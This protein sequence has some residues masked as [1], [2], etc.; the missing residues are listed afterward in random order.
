MREKFLKSTMKSI[1]NKYPDYDK[2]RLEIIEYGLESLYIMITK[3]IVISLIALLLNV[4]KE[5]LIIMILYN[6]IRTTAFGMHAKE[7]WQCYIISITLFIGGALLFKYINVSFYANALIG[8]VSY[9]FL[10]IYAPADTYKRPL[11][12]AKK[13]K[14]Y[15]IITV[16]N[17]SIFLILII[18]FKNSNISTALSLGL[19]DSMLMIHPLTYRM[20]HLPYNNYKTYNESYS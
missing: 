1:E 3:T 19:L 8:A 13:R 16:I 2:D 15:K 7:S 20:F 10:V 9:I 17:S 18:V 11:V 12:N 14:I 4:F 6:I 5:M